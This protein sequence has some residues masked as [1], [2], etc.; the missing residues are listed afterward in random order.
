MENLSDIHKKQ[1]NKEPNWIIKA[2]GRINILGEHLDYNGGNVLP[3]GVNRH[4]FFT[5]GSSESETPLI[6][7]F[8]IMTGE[9]SIISTQ[10]K[11]NGWRAY[12]RGSL[13]AL[14]E[15]GYK[16]DRRVEVAFYG[17]IPLGAGMSSSAALCCGLILGLSHTLGWGLDRKL[18]A[19]LG[20]R[21]EHIIGAN[22]G[23]MDQYA[24][25][26]SRKGHIID[27]DCSSMETSLIPWKLK[28]TALVL[29]NSKVDHQLAGTGSI[30]N[31]RRAV[32][33][34]ALN[35]LKKDDSNLHF[36]AKA[37]L[38]QLESLKT[39]FSKDDFAKVQYVIQEAQRVEKAKQAIFSGSAGDLGQLMYSTHE[40][41]QHLFEVSVPETDLLVDIGRETDGVYG[42]RM[43]GGGFG[44]CVLF[45]MEASTSKEA[46]K[47]IYESYL[48]KTGIDSP[49]FE[50]KIDNGIS[51]APAL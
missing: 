25:L 15:E 34:K 41:L 22:C 21:A 5:I 44:G 18:I 27:L 2:P 32:C 47:N 7:A 6:D 8:A 30:Y 29:V 13:L 39:H 51:I 23:L 35:I 45:L 20:Q 33:E 1:F 11:Y 31:K 24:V 36:L 10:D 16:L 26:F 48:Q 49:G 50:V 38:D 46:A 42:A 43:V 28:D 12:F 37:S 17:N 19:L 4:L 14:E 40:G 9:R 3:A